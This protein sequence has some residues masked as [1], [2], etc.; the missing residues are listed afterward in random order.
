M[1]KYLLTIMAVLFLGIAVSAGTKAKAAEGAPVTVSDIDYENFTMK[2][3]KNGNSI[4]YGSTDKKTWNEVEGVSEDG[5]ITVDISW[6]SSTADFNWYLK[7]DKNVTNLKVTFPKQSSDF[8]PKFDKLN[9]DFDMTLGQED[10]Q[11]FFY[12]KSTGYYWQKVYFDKYESLAEADLQAISYKQFVTEVE[13]LRYKGAKLCFRLGQIKGESA[14]NMGERPSKE[15]TVTVTKYAAAPSIKLNV[16]K[17]TFN[18]KDTME[19]TDDF[20]DPIWNSCTR[21]MTLED[22]APEL[23]YPATADSKTIYFRVAATQ[24]KPHSLAVAVTIPKQ[25]PPP[26]KGTDFTLNDGQNGKGILT[27]PTASA[28]NMYEYY[29]CPSDVTF[30]VNTAKWKTVRSNKPINISAKI[31]E[32]CTLYVRKKGTAENVNK[33]ISLVLPSGE[34]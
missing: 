3:H 28:D 32:D 9:G 16:I 21:N 25:G 19:W 22:I 6:V 2:I 17:L 12:R 23:T 7:G 30:S 15:V 11:Y 10:H 14:E 18:T 27:F 8:K 34:T 31:M 24:T 29:M 33:K 26:V 5:V 1:R 4:V 20:S 13:S